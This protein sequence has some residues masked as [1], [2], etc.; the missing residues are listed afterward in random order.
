MQEGSAPVLPPEEQP[1]PPKR[2]FPWGGFFLWLLLTPVI[3]VLTCAGFVW[4]AGPLLVSPPGSA[5]YAAPEAPVA[6]WLME[7]APTLLRGRE[8]TITITEAEA[9]GLLASLSHDAIRIRDV[10]ITGSQVTLRAVV[11]PPAS[12]PARFQRPWA[13]QAEANLRYFSDGR[14]RAEVTRLKVGPFPVP[15]IVVRAALVRSGTSVGPLD[16]LM[17]SVEGNVGR[18]IQQLSRGGARLKEV[19]FDHGSATLIL[20]PALP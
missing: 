19:R 15:L 8:A 4:F 17:L 9:A 20:E 11:D 12:V 1:T 7:A 3:L 5:T 13:V 2:R 16:P 10:A 18:E 6:S 14:L